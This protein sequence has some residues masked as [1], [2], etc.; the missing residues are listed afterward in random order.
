MKTKIMLIS[1]LASLCIFVFSSATWADGKKNRHPEKQKTE[2][3]KVSKHRSLDHHPAHWQKAK[4]T[5]AKKDYY[6]TPK[7][8]PRVWAKLIAKLHNL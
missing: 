4:H 6:R 8:A 3:Q 2:H 7:P 1:M 5:H